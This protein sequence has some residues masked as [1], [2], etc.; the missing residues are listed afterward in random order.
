[1]VEN[2]RFLSQIPEFASRRSRAAQQNRIQVNM[3]NTQQSSRQSNVADMQESRMRSNVAG[4]QNNMGNMQQNRMQNN[5]MGTQQSNVAGIQENRMQS[6]VAGMQDNRMQSNVA[7]M[8]ENRMQ[9]NL[10]GMQG[11]RMQSNVAGMQEKRMQEKV[12]TWENAY[13]KNMGAGGYAMSNEQKQL[14]R[15]LAAAKFVALELHLYLD[16]HPND[17]AAME[18][19]NQAVKRAE[20]LMEEYERRY[21]PIRVQSATGSVPWKWIQ[22]PWTWEQEV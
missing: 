10:A 21:G 7:G 12:K 5:V 22:S 16:T 20:S 4:M 3:P 9:S 11:N 13:G 6:S 8:Q 18:L 17:E 1:M 15:Q 14:Y 19:F 2:E